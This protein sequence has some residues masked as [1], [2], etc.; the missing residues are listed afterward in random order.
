MST[1]RK[2]EKS[3][4]GIIGIA[5]AAI[6]IASIFAVFAPSAATEAQ[7][8]PSAAVAAASGDSTTINTLRTYGEGSSGAGAWVPGEPIAN[9]VLDPATGNVAEQQPYTVVDDIFDPD[10]LGPDGLRN[11]G[12]EQSPRKDFITFNPVYM[13][14]LE[15]ANSELWDL[16]K[17]IKIPGDACEKVF[18][19][20]WYEPDYWDKDL[21]VSDGISYRIVDGGDGISQTSPV[22]ADAIGA[23][24]LPAALLPGYVIPGGVLV[25]VGADGVLDTS[26]GDIDGDGAIEFPNTDDFIQFIPGGDEHYATLMQEFTYMLTTA[27]Q[28]PP[29]GKPEPTSGLAGR[30][31]F[32]FPV[33]IR[34]ELFDNDFGYGLT[35]LDPTLDRVNNPS[36]V[37]VESERSLQAKTTI[38]A[39]FDG[40]GAIVGAT[41]RLD[42]DGVQLSGDELAIFA[43]PTMD[44]E[45]GAKLQF[46]D[47][48]IE[49]REVFTD[50]AGAVK[51]GIYYTGDKTSKFVGTQTI[52]A[53]DMVLVGTKMPVTYIAAGDDNL[54]NFPRGPF[55]IWVEGINLATG[56]ARIQ[57][58]RALGATHTAM[59]SAANVPDL[60]PGD[61]WWLKRFYVDGH[62]YNVVALYTVPQ[63]APATDD[64]FKFITIRTSIPKPT[65]EVI[66]LLIEQ[67]SVTLQE[68]GLNVPLSVMSPYNYEH[69]ILTDV[70]S[71]TTH[72]M[73]PAWLG[74]LQDHVKPITQIKGDYTTID[75]RTITIETTDQMFYVEEAV[76]PELTGEL[77]E[78]YRDIPGVADVILDLDGLVGF[79]DATTGFA[80]TVSIGTIVN[81]MQVIPG[82]ALTPL[83]PANLVAYFDSDG[84]A[85]WTNRVDWIIA[86][87]GNGVY[88]AAIDVV[89]W[90]GIGDAPVDGVSQLALLPASYFDDDLS[91]TYGSGEDIIIDAN[92]NGVY[93]TVPDLEW[94]YV[95]QYNSRPDHYT[96]FYLPKDHGLYLVTPNYNAPE[97]VVRWFREN[98]GVST[99]Q[100]QAAYP[101]G[102]VW[103]WYNVSATGDI[104]KYK[105]DAGLRVYGRSYGAFGLLRAG[106]PNAVDPIPVDLSNALVAFPAPAAMMF[107]DPNAN[108]YDVGDPV[109]FDADA[110]GTVTLNDIRIAN[111]PVGAIGSQVAAGDGDIG[112]TLV[113][114]PALA[115]M[116]FTDPDANGYDV[117]DPVYFDADVSG[118][119]TRND[120]RIANPPVGCVGSQVAAGD[121]DIG[122]ALVA[123]PAPAAMM[124]SD[125]NANLYDVGD[126]VY[127]D[128]DA[129]GTVTLND[130][131]IANPPVEV[132]YSQVGMIPEDAPYTR[133]LDVFDPEFP[134]APPKDTITF[135]PAWMDEYYNGGEDL[136][137]LYAQL[138]IEGH[139]AREKVFARQW[140]E[141]NHWDKDITGDNI[142]NQYI[143]DGGNGLSE[144]PDAGTELEGDDIQVVPTDASCLP[145][146][147]LILP[148]PKGRIESTPGGDDCVRG[149]GADEFYPAVMQEFSY[150]YVDTNDQPAHGQPGKSLFAFPIGATKAELTDDFGYGLTTFDVDF[151]GKHDVVTVHSEQSLFGLTGIQAD[152][153]GD[154]ALDFLDTDGVGLSGDELVIFTVENINLGETDNAMLLD[155][156]LE[157][158]TVYDTP[159]SVSLEISTTEGGA[160]PLDISPD[161]IG[162]VTL[163]P[164]DMAI[165]AFQ[166]G[167][168]K[169]LAGGDNLGGG[170]DGIPDG[171]WFVYVN[172]INTDSRRV[173]VTIGRALGATHTAMEMAADM[174]DMTPGDPWYLKRFYVDG[175]EY[176]VVALRITPADV[177]NPGDEPFEFKYI[178]I[179]TPVQKITTIIEQHSWASQNYTIGD[180]ISVMPPFNFEH[181]VRA[182]V[183]EG[184]LPATTLHALKYV[185]GFL[186]NKPAMNITIVS[187]STEEEF[188]GELKE[189]YDEY[190]ANEVWKT[191]WF[192]TL[193]N[194]YTEFSL[195]AGQKYLLTSDWRA[196]QGV[197]QFVNFLTGQPIP[198]N[199]GAADPGLPTDVNPAAAVAPLF[200][201]RVK[202]WYDPT[203]T[204]DLYVNTKPLPEKVDVSGVVTEVNGELVR[205][206]ATVTIS[207]ATSWST[208]ATINFLGEYSVTGIAPGEYTVVAS[209]AGYLDET[210]TETF[211]TAEKVTVDFTDNT[212]LIPEEPNIDYVIECIQLW[213]KGIINMDKVL[214][215]I[216]AWSTAA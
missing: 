169:I 179:R 35:S 153:D 154:G 36:I 56:A 156:M 161:S 209:K 202:F 10:G 92:G 97:K 115:A 166:L 55:F 194:A 26:P 95:E 62:E 58:G 213:S 171:A 181:T 111:P 20:Q 7:S 105:D 189:V 65:G 108:L 9:Q 47:H 91:G 205:P 103:F 116:M 173:S 96:E 191:M 155:N 52:T 104:K 81:D 100:A 34:E 101:D 113:A 125:P 135:N 29:A 88:N 24:N 82:S 190:P 61:P 50:P 32:V 126:P 185:G 17:K 207:N 199:I 49:V 31:R 182:D 174:P 80:G 66:D 63:P 139:D 162:T 152:F 140:Y 12:D 211:L 167:I 14:E 2:S 75:S 90:A 109:Y 133:D 197:Y 160:N 53:G 216:G 141:P 192:D 33:G 99:I 16:S 208:T 13:C 73:P 168:T 57:I 206:P 51:V 5:L 195:P 67:H 124:F 8:S 86:D 1:K 54:A 78:K 193:P 23:D 89:I 72:T 144:S 150:M 149:A 177:I 110:S 76:E 186:K 198:A 134:Q 22:A 3:K 69:A 45:S 187:E 196:P 142:A 127:F 131:R 114:F 215:V 146:E 68:Y 87:N 175:H 204:T 157:V 145:G 46:L 200:Q 121:G 44:L 27:S 40:D 138:S 183:Q 38:G 30:V 164:G 148:G 170:A 129:S 159:A 84:N 117:G 178:T 147:I 143:V 70:Q 180:K 4:R 37:S 71:V 42:P 59:E 94:W 21:D 123:F 43:L 85:A 120:I 39:D 151:D 128:A 25:V 74:A 107:S 41:E 214:R 28:L 188:I 119:V 77:K 6:M 64:N 212:G 210:I 165:A 106:D 18:A 19:R 60:T 98:R 118:T 83:I 203:D 136:A 172:N 11:T 132:V 184:W 122:N 15:T 48:M 163:G 158:R 176:N 130:I 102:R 112:N 93:D 137:A 201:N 79:P